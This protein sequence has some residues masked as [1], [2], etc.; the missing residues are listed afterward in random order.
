ML[1]VAQHR[2][3]VGEQQRLFESMRD[4]DDRDAALLEIADEVEEVFLLLRRQRCGRL[5]EDDDLGAVQNRAC[6]LDHLLLGRAKAADGG[7]RRDVEIERLQEL[8]R[9][10]VDAAQAVVELLLPEKQ[11]LRDRHGRHQAVLLEHHGDAEIARLQRRLRRDIG[12]VD[13]HGPRGQRHHARHHLGERRF[14]GAVLADQCVDLAAAKVEVDPVD[15]GHAG[16]EFCRLAQRECDVAH[17]RNSSARP[18]S[19]NRRTRPGPL[20]IRTRSSPISMAATT[21]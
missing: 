4:E 12:A 7:G 17:G 18:A 15:G 19:G 6:D 20:A 21:P 16:V 11:V 10:D 9:G 5:V 13:H 2:D 14:A 1:A 3:A 8:L